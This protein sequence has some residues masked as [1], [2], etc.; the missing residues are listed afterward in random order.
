MKTLNEN[1]FKME[2]I[3]MDIEPN[4]DNVKTTHCFQSTNERVTIHIAEQDGIYY[5]GY[6]IFYENG[7][8][9][10]APVNPDYGVFRSQASAEGFIIAQIAMQSYISDYARVIMM[11]KL[12]NLLQ[13]NLFDDDDNS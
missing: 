6:D 1:P 5:F 12:Q 4:P 8:V 2:R 3:L 7:R 9:V 13:Y 11:A 10:S